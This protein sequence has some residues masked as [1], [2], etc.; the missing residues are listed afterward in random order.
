MIL[1]VGLEKGINKEKGCKMKKSLLITM[2]LFVPV[3]FGSTASFAQEKK[4]C[5]KPKC[6][7]AVTEKDCGCEKASPCQGCECTKAEQ[8]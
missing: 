6:E 5:L 3:L 2:L 4:C 7:C 8:K 1:F